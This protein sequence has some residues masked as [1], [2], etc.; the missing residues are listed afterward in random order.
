MLELVLVL[1]MM[2]SVLVLELVLPPKAA[3]GFMPDQW[4]L[5]CL[6]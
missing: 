6:S 4:R 2:V 3:L 1:V 5:R